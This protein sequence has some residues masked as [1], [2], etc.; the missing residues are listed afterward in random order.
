MDAGV[1][2]QLLNPFA[3]LLAAQC[4]GVVLIHE[5]EQ[6]GQPSGEILLVSIF[7]GQ[8]IQERVHRAVP[9]PHFKLTTLFPELI[10]PCRRSERFQKDGN[11]NLQHDPVGDDGVGE[12]EGGELA[13]DGPVLRHRRHIR[14][15][16]GPAR[17]LHQGDEGT[18]K[19]AKLHLVVVP[20][21][22][23]T[24]AGIYACND[25]E[26][27]KGVDHGHDGLGERQNDLAQRRDS[28][29]EPDDAHG[30]QDPDGTDVGGAGTQG[31]ERAGD[32]KDV[33]PVPPIGDEGEE[34]VGKGVDD[35]L[36]REEHREYCIGQIEVDGF[37]PIWRLVPHFP[38]RLHLRDRG[39]KAQ[40]DADQGRG[41]EDIGV[42]VLSRKFLAAPVP[43]VGELPL[44]RRLA[45]RG[46]LLVQPRGLGLILRLQVV[47]PPRVEPVGD[48]ADNDGVA[49]DALVLCMIEV[50]ARTG[51]PFSS[52]LNGIHFFQGYLVNNVVG[53][54]VDLGK[55]DCFFCVH[56]PSWVPRPMEED[57]QHKV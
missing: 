20:E 40:H 15:P 55:E 44:P 27:N 39:S 28:A 47:H 10:V 22:G 2:V 43:G 29:E 4:A 41:L 13:V 17:D 23:D 37:G 57:S 50:V 36:D 34:P 11:R 45:Q 16:R 52:V 12:D 7:A 1:E 31:A 5:L 38:D 26:D 35:Q 48:G 14:Y 3:E 53:L 51:I 42:E 49:E 32:D 21:Q 24:H 6:R 25:E 56:Y 46:Q 9:F 54:V 30:A 33:D 19:H 18:I 8:M